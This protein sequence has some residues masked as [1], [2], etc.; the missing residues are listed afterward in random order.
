MDRMWRAGAIGALLTGML[1]FGILV[2]GR[3]DDSASELQPSDWAAIRPPRVFD[4]EVDV[5][6]YH[7]DNFRTGQYLSET[8]LTPA[9]VNSANF[10]KVGFL[11]V[12]GLVDAEPLYV[13]N[14]AV[15]GAP[16]KVIFVATEHDLVYAF[17]A[18]NF[19]QL[20]RV[21][22][23]G[24][25]ETTSD[26]RGCQ[27]V[28]PEIGIT[29]T[30]VIDLSAGAHGAISV[31]AMSKDREGRYFQRLHALDLTTGAEL[32]GSP[33][34]IAATYSGRG[35]GNQNGRLIFNA[36]QYKERA[37]LL[38]AHGLIYT[39]WSSHC[40]VSPYTSWVIAYNA[41]TLRQAGVLN[42]TPNGTEGA[43]WMAGAGPAA[44]EAGNV[45][46]L[47][48]NGTFDTTLSERGF[49]AQGDY[50]N[51]F[52]KLV[53]NGG[54]LTVADYFTMQNTVEQSEQ[55]E[56]L[57]SGGIALLP[58]MKDVS[59]RVRHLAVGA[60]KDQ[61]IY[62]VDR[63]SMGKFHADGDRAYEKD[64]W[65]IGGMEFGAPAYF[66]DAVYYGAYKDNLRAFDFV[67][68][69]L[70]R[71]QESQTSQKFDYP[72][73]TPSVSANG[74]SNGI[75]WAVENSA[76]AVLHAYEASDLSKE[77]YN[78]NQAGER[79][80]FENNKFVTPMI[81]NGRVHVGTKT[82]VAVFGLLK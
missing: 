75:V 62:L 71:L 6:T 7:N 56:D 1:A 49:P 28:T 34:T 9:N 79:D 41:S 44:D 58:D 46:V 81:A 22:V 50:G 32:P 36:K 17:D 43:I 39:T 72:G 76:P 77:L 35:A 40:D 42:L 51:A 57:G 82:G 25:G 68:A 15:R 64:I 37:A 13:S 74:N 65:A 38:L 2:S 20:W 73:T 55:D 80:Q 70:P 3:S 4:N 78:S 45:Y 12:R 8:S 11:P 14:L 33:T 60:G 53:M 16:R 26:D 47:T 19:A 66:R 63:D 54:T 31:V 18:D 30:P 52:V 48:G 10:G 59:G 29:A 27:Q 5:L 23:L 61:I 21:S 67:H 24:D 69:T